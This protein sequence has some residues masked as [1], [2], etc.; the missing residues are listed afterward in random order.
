MGGDSHIE[1]VGL[2][3]GNF[4]KNPGEVSTNSYITHYL[5]SYVLASLLEKVL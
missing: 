3:V 4:E 5:L 2:I 1:R